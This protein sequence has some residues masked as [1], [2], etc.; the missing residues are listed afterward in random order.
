MFFTPA[1]YNMKQTADL[2]LL[3]LSNGGYDGLGKIR[4]KE[5]E[6]AANQMGFKSFKVLDRADIPDGPWPWD[7]EAVVKQIDLEV[8]A[9][10]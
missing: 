8:K 4:E 3:V 2:Y 9:Y 5:M 6:K 10:K 1:I 7:T